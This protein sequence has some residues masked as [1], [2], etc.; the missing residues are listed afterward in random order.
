MAA[1]HAPRRRA[2]QQAYL[3]RAAGKA[4]VDPI[5]KQMKTWHGRAAYLAAD[6][7]HRLLRGLAL[8]DVRQRLGDLETSILTALNDW[9]AGRPTDDPSGLVTDAEKSARVILAT[10]DALKQRIDRG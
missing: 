8:D 6:A 1:T 9:R 10:I 5:A 2:R 4:A 3:I 7:N